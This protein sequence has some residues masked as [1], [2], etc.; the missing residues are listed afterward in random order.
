MHVVG[1]KM[2]AIHYTSFI[3]VLPL[4]WWW[5]WLLYS[6]RTGDCSLILIFIVDSCCWFHPHEIEGNVD[7]CE[8]LEILLSYVEGR[9]FWD[10]DTAGHWTLSQVF[11]HLQ[12]HRLS[13]N[14][15]S[16]FSW[17]L[18]A[19]TQ[20]SFLFC[21]SA[22][23]PLWETILILRELVLKW[24][25]SFFFLSRSCL[26]CFCSTTSP[27]IQF[28]GPWA[29]RGRWRGKTWTHRRVG[30]KRRRK[31]R[32]AKTGRESVHR[33]LASLLLLPLVSKAQ[34]SSLPPL[35]F[36]DH[37]VNDREM[38]VETKRKKDENGTSTSA[39]S[40]AL[41]PAGAA[42]HAAK[43]AR[44][45]P[46]CRLL[47]KQQELQSLVRLSAVSGEGEEQEVQIFQQGEG[48]FAETRAS[49]LGG[50]KG[51]SLALLWARG[52]RLDPLRSAEVRWYLS[53]S[54]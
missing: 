42:A 8:R 12:A 54:T 37:N 53:R 10:W 50:Q 7:N 39:L 27:T 38:S 24:T 25:S 48:R 11:F 35:H 15:D 18:V 22:Q 29:E 51:E 32:I 16:I 49:V 33:T 43:P 13:S 9:S 4:L 19:K 34:V 52:S 23:I 1:L 21:F 31:R 28:P 45:P 14:L 46:P 36:Q 41:R 3:R 26:N 44:L 30:P 47:Q 40:D 17:L 6:V 2:N 20:V 5:W